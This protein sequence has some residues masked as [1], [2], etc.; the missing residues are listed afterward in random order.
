MSPTVFSCYAPC[1]I[2]RRVAWAKI[3]DEAVAW[4]ELQRDKRLRDHRNKVMAPR[5]SLFKKFIGAWAAKLW[6]IGQDDDF[7]ISSKVLSCLDYVLMP[8]VQSVLDVREGAVVT[9]EVLEEHVE[10]IL[11]LLV[12]DWLD[13]RKDEL[14]AKLE[15]VFDSLP[16][17]EEALHLATSLFDCTACG[18][19]FMTFMEVLEHRCRYE[20]RKDNGYQT[21]PLAWQTIARANLR[22]PGE[23]FEWD[24]K[25][26]A[27]NRHVFPLKARALIEACGLD[28]GRATASDMEKCKKRMTCSDCT[29][30]GP[31][32]GGGY[33]VFNWKRAVRL[34]SILHEGAS[35]LIRL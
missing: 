32:K 11:P 25:R 31:S 7:P 8:Q 24:A 17:G 9:W 22:Q 14:R 29:E 15:E 26:F 18:E 2:Q 35:P 13:D 10:P 3:R 4:I 30:R 23:P 20:I 28:A 27:V 12:F 16:K 19:R 6:P 21:K 33:E 34:L 5:F 1:F